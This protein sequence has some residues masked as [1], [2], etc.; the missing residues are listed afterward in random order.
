MLKNSAYIKLIGTAYTLLTQQDASFAVD[1]VHNLKLSHQT[2]P[3]YLI[4]FA[5][6][7]PKWNRV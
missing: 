7:D 1:L 3:N 5:E 2:V 6:K 4:Q